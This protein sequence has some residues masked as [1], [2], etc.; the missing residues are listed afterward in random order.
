MVKEGAATRRVR[1]DSMVHTGAKVQPEKAASASRL[2]LG[3]LTS[4][5]ALAIGITISAGSA[6][7]QDSLL[8]VGDSLSDNGNLFGLTGGTNPASPPYS[9]GRFSNG[10]VFSEILPGLLGV[11]DSAVTN[12]AIGGAE[13]GTANS[14]D[15]VN[16]V[17]GTL[18][19]P[20][21]V[22]PD[23][24]V[25]YWIGANDYFNRLP[26]GEDA[27][28]VISDVNANIATGVGTLAAV[29]HRRFLV[30]NLPNLGDTPGGVGSGS[31]ADLNT[32]TAAHNSALQA[33]IAGLETATGAD[34]TLV[35][36]NSLFADV[37]ASPS[38]YGFTNTTVPCLVG[39][40]A[41]GA[42]ATPEAEATTLFFDEIHPTTN[43]H[44]FV[45]QFAAA[46]YN[47]SENVGA[48]VAAR[49]ELGLQVTR[50]QQRLA[51]GR[52]LSVRAGLNDGAKERKNKTT[53]MFI[54][55]DLGSGD[56][57]DSTSNSGYDYDVYTT[58]VGV[59]FRVGKGA[60]GVAVGYAQGEQTLANNGGDSESDNYMA[61]AYATFGGREAHVDL[62]IGYGYSE[63]DY[64][65]PTDFSARPTA[66]AETNGTTLFGT[67]SG[68]YSWT[69][70]TVAFGPVA[71]MRWS[72][73]NV[74]GYTE[75]DAGPLSL[76]V[77]DNDVE[78]ITG[79]AG[80][81]FTAR[82]ETDGGGYVA[83][84]LQ[85]VYEQDFGGDEVVGAALSSGERFSGS[86][87][88]GE[89]AIVISGGLEFALSKQFSAQLLAE[90]AVARDNGADYGVQGRVSFKF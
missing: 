85:A 50:A 24:V 44:N 38:T 23:G 89:G 40:A 28:A 51:Q 14:I 73:S 74:D 20:A 88:D 62:S 2:R 34:I 56:R 77:D 22:T 35:D 41:T 26:T 87:D 52:L 37:Q 15:A 64:T 57:D 13:S 29:G 55:G 5:A 18:T 61:L 67:L 53:S 72:R 75:Q 68:G 9:N 1:P 47:L 59:D 70:E 66:T 54:L 3:L 39:G 46:T 27:N 25:T 6:H 76:T 80:G 86:T 58:M 63:Y 45:A 84:H 31:G 60:V 36:I 79:F 17:N 32:A 10:Q 69:T 42:C 49:T 30:F 83:A 16:Q 90:T 4:V 7:A 19:N 71:G 33:T 81:Q 48:D 8:V 65:R 43:A 78:N 11:D 21:L 12:I 82:F